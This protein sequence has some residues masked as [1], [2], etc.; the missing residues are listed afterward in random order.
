MQTLL[1]FSLKKSKCPVK[2]VVPPVP[3][4]CPSFIWDI[5][6]LFD[7]AHRGKEGSLKKGAIRRL[8]RKRQVRLLTMEEKYSCGCFLGAETSPGFSAL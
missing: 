4:N 5:A 1:L 6:L 7:E 2:L 8:K 3:L